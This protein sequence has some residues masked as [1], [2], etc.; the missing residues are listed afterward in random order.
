MHSGLPEAGVLFCQCAESGETRQA[1]IFA[2]G[3]LTFREMF[4]T[5][6]ASQL[7]PRFDPPTSPTEEPMNKKVWLGFVVT[8]VLMEIVA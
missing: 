8:F 2:S 5:Y 7:T 1:N 4:T 6:S 3:G